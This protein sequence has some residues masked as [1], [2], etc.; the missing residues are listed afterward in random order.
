M[1]TDAKIGLLLALVF[2]VAITFVING[3]PDFLSKKDKLDVTGT[4]IGH[5]SKPDEPGIIDR[6]SRQAAELLSKKT[7]VSP[8]VQ[9]PVQTPVSVSENVQTS[10]N[11][12]TAYQQP[13]IPAASEVVKSPM[14]QAAISQQPVSADLQSAASSAVQSL[15]EEK[16]AAVDGKTYEVVEGDSLVTIAQ[17]VYGSQLG[18]KY[19]NIQGIY[20]ANK[21]IMKSRDSLQIGQKL[22]IPKLSEKEQALVNTGFFE[23][24]TGTPK[25]P[26]A[27]AKKT[28]T[29]KTD[30]K[31]TEPAAGETKAF[32]EYVVKENDTLWKIAARH[33]GDGN[34]YDEIVQLNKTMNPDKLVV[35][36]KLKLPAK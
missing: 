19:A 36:M 27:D 24:T 17:K 6:S 33:L 16:A 32:R 23:K 31:K 30:V 9:S 28:E 14:P 18:S 25:S 15:A 12:N 4:Y 2:I 13:I 20:E 1:T 29:A 7:I 34:R 5:Y 3:L 26:A 22:I 21:G 11:T 10:A 35:G 8:P